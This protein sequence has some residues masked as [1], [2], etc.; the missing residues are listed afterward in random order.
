MLNVA[1]EQ[2]EVRSEAVKEL[3]RFENEDIDIKTKTDLSHN[4][5]VDLTR[6]KLIAEHFDINI[7]NS[8]CD[9]YCYFMVSKNRMGRTEIVE[10]IRERE[11]ETLEEKQNFFKKLFNR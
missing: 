6:I 8:L 10:M 2:E 1:N 11:R 9:N 7:L 5:I 3:F 4:E